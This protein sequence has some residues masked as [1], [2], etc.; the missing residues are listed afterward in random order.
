L[1][2]GDSI[3]NS[4]PIPGTIYS[5][6][7]HPLRLARERFG[8]DDSPRCPFDHL[9]HSDTLIA[10]HEDAWFG[11]I[12][13]LMSRRLARS[14]RTSSTKR[15]MSKRNQERNQAKPGTDHERN[16]GQ[17]TASCRYRDAP[18]FRNTEQPPHAPTRPPRPDSPCTPPSALSTGSGINRGRTPVHPQTT[19]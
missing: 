6:L 10:S 8:R 18:S 14:P 15:A 11:R 12:R 5:T 13:T 2:S 4:Q 7:H 19:R 16:Q 1:D 9:A 17:A 3:R